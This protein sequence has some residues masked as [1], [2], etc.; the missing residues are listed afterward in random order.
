MGR[1]RMAIT[2]K[3]NFESAHRLYGHEGKCRYLHGHSYKLELSISGPLDPLYRIVDF[4]VIKSLIGGWINNHLD[5]N[6]ILHRMD[7]LVANTNPEVRQFIFGREPFLLN[8]HPTVECMA[9]FLFYQSYKILKPRGLRVAKIKLWE[10]ESNYALV[11]GS[12]RSDDSA[13][14]D[15]QEGEHKEPLRET[16]NGEDKPGLESV[17]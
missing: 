16:E 4:D 2:K 17:R 11:L 1:A 10:T 15:S 3:F 5:H 14:R 9:D 8:N 12:G 13:E 6:T 7:P